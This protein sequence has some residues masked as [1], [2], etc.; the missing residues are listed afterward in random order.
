MNYEIGQEMSQEEVDRVNDFYALTGV[1][2]TL[3]SWVY[4]EGFTLRYHGVVEKVV[5]KGVLTQ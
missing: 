4:G 5:I 1:P 3:I 2:Y